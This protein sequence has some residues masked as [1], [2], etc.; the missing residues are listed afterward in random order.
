MG[1][2]ERLTP[3]RAQTQTAVYPLKSLAL[4]RTTARPPRAVANG[5]CFINQSLLICLR[6]PPNTADARPFDFKAE[7]AK[8]HSFRITGRPQS[9][10]FQYPRRPSR[11]I[12]PQSIS[13][14]SVAR[15]GRIRCIKL[16]RTQPTRVKGKAHSYSD[17]RAPLGIQA[18]SC[19]RL[20]ALFI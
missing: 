2:S 8:T 1:K 17:T 9:L 20:R 4:G 14:F 5:N 11:G 12:V 15:G 6:G 10:L 3:I 19:R 18:R 16:A 13:N 7:T